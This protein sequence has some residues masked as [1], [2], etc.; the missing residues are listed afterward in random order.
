[1]VFKIISVHVLIRLIEKKS[2]INIL[3]SQINQALIKHSF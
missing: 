2:K 3:K 1:M